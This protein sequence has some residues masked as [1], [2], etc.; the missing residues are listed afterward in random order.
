MLGALLVATM[1]QGSP[2]LA[3]RGL[4]QV[5]PKPAA[6]VAGERTPASGQAPL[7]FVA[8]VQDPLKMPQPVAYFP[9][10]GKPAAP[11]SPS[12]AAAAVRPTLVEESSPC[13]ACLLAGE[14]LDSALPNS[15]YK[16]TGS[17]IAWEDDAT[18]GRVVSCDSVSRLGA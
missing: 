9:L 17:N 8:Q 1:G 3:S 6:G 5:S 7:L 10:T 4:Q 14:S 12:A 11:Q 2:A 18:F 13:P 16:G 15:S